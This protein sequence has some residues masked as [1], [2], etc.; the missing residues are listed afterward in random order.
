MPCACAAR[1]TSTSCRPAANGCPAG[2]QVQVWLGHVQAGRLREA[3]E[4]IIHDNPFPAIHGRVCYHPCESACNRD[5]V[6]GAVSI[7]AVERFLGDL[8]LAEGWLPDGT[9]AP[10]G[11]RV[12]VVGGGPGGLA[13]AWHLRRLGH[14]VEL[15]D[16]GGEAGGMMRYG[17]PA[18][19]LPRSVLDG[20]IGRLR[21]IGVQMKCGRRVD[22][23][24]HEW[25]DGGFDAVFVAVGAHLSK[26]TEGSAAQ[27]IDAWL[28]GKPLDHERAL[29]IAGPDR[30]KLWY[31]TDAAMRTEPRVG[32]S[33]RLASFDEV[34]KGLDAEAARYEARRCFSCGTCFECDGCFAACPEDAIV[35]LGPGLR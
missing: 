13:A 10:S 14:E 1:S 18:Y 8:A 16:A 20:E 15:I 25:S 2:E 19:R 28:R 11:N 9:P 33:H 23:L 6:D 22:D 12:L 27:Q 32:V 3:W 26:R 7:H 4:T 21:R 29:P 34:V 24:E 31:Y 17:I 5:T 35:K 30:L